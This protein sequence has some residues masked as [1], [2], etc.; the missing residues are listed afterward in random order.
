MG[1]GR[2]G[3]LGQ[4]QATSDGGA[5]NIPR[6]HPGNHAGRRMGDPDPKLGGGGVGG[7]E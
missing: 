3:S 1:Q 7:G 5:Q 6:T 2:Q 4:W